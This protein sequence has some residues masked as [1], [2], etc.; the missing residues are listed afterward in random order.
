MV[1]PC[2]W[3]LWYNMYTY[4]I[5]YWGLFG[6]SHS[7]L[8]AG[9]CKRFFQRIMGRGYRYYRFFYSV[10]ALLSL[11]LILGYQ[12]SIPSRALWRVN[13]PA[14]II[15]GILALAGLLIMIVCILKYF[16]YL[17]GIDVFFPG[18]KKAAHL[19]TDGLH[20]F[21]RH[22]LYFGTLLTIWS[23]FFLFPIMS[24]LLACIMITL[25]TCIGTLFEEQKL[26]DEFGADYTQYQQEVPMLIPFTKWKKVKKERVY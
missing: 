20:R 26:V 23:F 2:W 17:S 1:V 22:P 14:G 25:Y 24:N 10:F 15:A 5:L 8:A 21:V 19:E 16:S 6:V 3:S 9:W 13:W 12:Y 4:L 18:D 7:V 11:V